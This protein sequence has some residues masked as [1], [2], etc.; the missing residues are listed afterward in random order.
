MLCCVVYFH[1]FFRCDLFWQTRT[2]SSKF[3]CSEDDAGHPAC[4]AMTVC[5]DE[6]NTH[7][8]SADRRST[9]GTLDLPTSFAVLCVIT[10]GCA[11]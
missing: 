1:V 9:I 6:N 8:H 10:F 7:A 3:G 4:A 2:W 11:L 5:A